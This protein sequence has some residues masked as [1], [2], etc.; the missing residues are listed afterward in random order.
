MSWLGAA[1][2]CEAE[3]DAERAAVRAALRAQLREIA[4]RRAAVEALEV[5]AAAPLTPSALRVGNTV[6]STC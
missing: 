1:A 3:E 2:R 4:E 5:R 6:T